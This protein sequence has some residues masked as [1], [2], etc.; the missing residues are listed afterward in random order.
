[1]RE[2]IE[3]VNPVLELAIVL[4]DWRVARLLRV[5]GKTICTVHSAGDMHEL[6]VKG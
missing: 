5:P 4:L 2:R 1:M 6:E 3:L